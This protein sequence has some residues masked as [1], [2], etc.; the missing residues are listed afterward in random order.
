MKDGNVYKV[1]I[2]P[3]NRCGVFAATV[4]DAIATFDE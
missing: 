4:Q 2:L 3:L 1:F